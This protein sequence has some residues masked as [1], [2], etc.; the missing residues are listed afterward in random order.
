MQGQFIK[1]TDLAADLGISRTPVREALMLLVSE[2][3]VELIPQR[4]AY[5]P[6]ISG[7]EISE[8]MELRSVLESYA[9]RLVITEKRVPAERM[10]TT[11]DLQAAVPDY[12]DPESARHFIRSGTL[13]HNSS[14]TPLEA[15]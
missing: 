7:R 3:L 8:L 9:S 5:V 13:F 2:G 6:A 14:L 11:L 10:Q 12:D 1:E 15:S 4:G